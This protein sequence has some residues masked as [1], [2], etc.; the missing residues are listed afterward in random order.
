MKRFKI[1]VTTALDICLPSLSM[2]QN[3]N[4]SNKQN[5]KR[6]ESTKGQAARASVNKKAMQADLKKFKTKKMAPKTLRMRSDMDKIFSA[7]DLKKLTSLR[8]QMEIMR[9]EKKKAIG[10]VNETERRKTPSPEAIRMRELHKK[11]KLIIVQE[12]GVIGDKYGTEI[13]KF[14]SRM[15][16]QRNGCH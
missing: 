4:Q 16:E 3:E 10:E 7:P 11:R 9:E 15:A 2:A 13:D 14:Q 6:T 1:L 12:A 8:R 5:Q